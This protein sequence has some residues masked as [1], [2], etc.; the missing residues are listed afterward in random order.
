LVAVD[1]ARELEP[2]VEDSSQ[3]ARELA[4][5]LV[6]DRWDRKALFLE[7]QVSR[8]MTLANPRDLFAHNCY[9]ARSQSYLLKLF[10][11][12]VFVETVL[13]PAGR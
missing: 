12:C 7:F 4:P 11:F 13:N 6:P 5:D 2:A 3:E 1:Q 9:A 10:F 8:S